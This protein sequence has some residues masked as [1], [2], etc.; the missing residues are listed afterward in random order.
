MNVEEL[1]EALRAGESA[2]ESVLGEDWALARGLLDGEVVDPGA[3][4]DE[5]AL[6]V[7][8]ASVTMRRPTPAELLSISPDREVAKAAAEPCTAS[9][10]RGS[11]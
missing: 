9:A 1:A 4:P 6:A 3:L 5:L 8:E 11:R 2:P 10:R 7:L